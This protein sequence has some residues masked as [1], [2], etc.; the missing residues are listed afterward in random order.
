M[1]NLKVKLINLGVFSIVTMFSL[2]VFAAPNSIA[3][4]GNKITQTTKSVGTGGIIIK[5]NLAYEASDYPQFY[6]GE[7][8]LRYNP[9]VY[10][11]YVVKLQHELN[12]IHNLN[13]SDSYLIK[14]I[15]EDGY[16][17]EDTLS[18]VQAL[19]GFFYIGG[20]S[21]CAGLTED[22]IVGEYTW[23]KLNLL[24]HSF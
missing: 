8:T 3:T 4:N 13:D 20:E 5:P 23:G 15:S 12:I 10:S 17:G 18:D 11:S 21:Y 16:F 24:S 7:P 9:N 6:R 1:K 14:N 22:G 2:P 19:Q